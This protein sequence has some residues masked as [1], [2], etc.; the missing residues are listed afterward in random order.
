MPLIYTTFSCQ[1]LGLFLTSRATG[2]VA[3]KLPL[4]YIG[5]GIGPLSLSTFRSSGGGRGTLFIRSIVRV[6]PCLMWCVA[7]VMESAAEQI[8]LSELHSHMGGDLHENV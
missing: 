5:L 4:I 6:R 2:V 3:N 7:R 8:N 1:L